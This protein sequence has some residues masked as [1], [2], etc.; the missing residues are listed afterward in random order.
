MQANRAAGLAC[1]HH[2]FRFSEF[3]RPGRTV[4][5]G[6][7]IVQTMAPDDFGSGLTMSDELWSP[8][9][10]C[11]QL[12]GEDGA[13]AGWRVA[14]PSANLLQTGYFSRPVRCSSS[15]WV[16]LPLRFGGEPASL[17]RPLPAC[18]PGAD[19]AGTLAGQQV[20]PDRATG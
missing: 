6:D 4:R 5:L 19:S 7:V 15:G 9:S 20:S 10:R 12:A 13:A 3:F 18:A 17:T 8:A 1:T 11:L 2:H 16:V 14:Q